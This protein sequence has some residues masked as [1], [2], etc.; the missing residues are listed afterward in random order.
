MLVE[1]TNLRIFEEEVTRGDQ[2]L[3]LDGIATMVG[4]GTRRD[5][6]ESKGTANRVGA[7]VELHAEKGS[8][9]Q[10][11]ARQKESRG[12]GVVVRRPRRRSYT[13]ISNARRCRRRGFVP[14]PFISD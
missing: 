5:H 11:I 1:R 10:K 4:M 7:G 8:G 9:G 14:L 3:G 12:R 6:L 2:S 13:S